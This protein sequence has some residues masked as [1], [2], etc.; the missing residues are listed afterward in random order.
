[1]FCVASCEPEHVEQLAAL[2]SAHAACAVPGA[3]VLPAT[4]ARRLE[5]D[6]G[7]FVLDP[8]VETRHTL[9]AIARE[10]VVAAG[11]LWRFA[12]KPR[13]SEHYR[14]AAELRWFCFWPGDEEAAAALLDRAIEHAGPVGRF[15]LTGDLPDVPVHGIPDAWAHVEALAR[16]RGFAYDGRT[17]V[18]L[19]ARLAALPD[20]ETPPA[21][22]SLRR[23]V[24]WSGDAVLIADRADGPIA[25]M[26]LAVEGRV[27][28]LWG[29]FAEQGEVEAD[30]ARWLWLEA[31]EW[32]RL[33]GC[34]R[35]VA[36]L[37]EDEP[38]VEQA[39]ALGLRPVTRLRRG[40]T[41]RPVV[42]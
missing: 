22:C 41:L 39:A 32:L 15:Y 8:W 13:V 5:R 3:A 35:V 17:E 4:I 6:P 19:V 42:S 2:L 38:G 16:E 28:E 20:S 33:G 10:R 14:G 23:G 36:N 31:F 7:E 18:L 26:E 11:Q 37:V 1:M 30:V 27:G 29:P 12:G 34:D 25:K 24:A 21:G 9:V 40:W